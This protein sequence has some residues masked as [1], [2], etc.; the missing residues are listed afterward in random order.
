NV[1]DTYNS[2]TTWT[3]PSDVTSVTVEA[4]GGGGGGGGTSGTS[5]GSGGGGGGY[6]RVNNLTVT[7]G[8][9]Y[10]VTVGTAGAGGAG[11]S[12]NGGNGGDSWFI[13]SAS[14]LAKGGN[15]GAANSGAN[16]TGGSSG[17]G[18]GDAKYSGGNGA[19][20]TGTY[21]GGGGGSGG[22]ANNGNTATTSTGAT[23]VT[24]GGNGGNGATN[25]DGSAP[26]TPPG[27]GGGGGRKNSGGNRD[28]GSGSAGRIVIRYVSSPSNNQCNGRLTE[29]YA[30]TGIFFSTDY[31][32]SQYPPM[33][34]RIL[35]GTN[36]YNVNPTGAGQLNPIIGQLQATTHNLWDA[37]QTNAFGSTAAAVAGLSSPKSGQSSFSSGT[38][39]APYNAGSA[40]AGPQTGYQLDDTAQVGPWQRIYYQGSRMG[41]N[42]TGPAKTA[43]INEPGSSLTSVGGNPTSVGWNLSPGN[44]LPAGTNA[45]RWALG[46]LTVGEIRYV[47]ISLRLTSQVP[48][49][50]IIN[51]SEVF[52]GDA[53]NADDGKDNTWRYHVP[54]VADNNSNLYVLKTVVGYYS[55]STF[56]PN[57]GTYI[58]AG[59]KVRY[60]IVYLNSGNANQTNVILSDTLPCQTNANPVSNITVISG[61][62]SAATSP[63]LTAIPAGNC[64]TTPFTR[65]T[66]SFN[67]GVGV[68]LLPA[69]SGVI[70]FDVQTNSVTGDTVSN[71]AKLA[72]TLI[73]AGVVSNAN[74]F[75]ASSPNLVITKTTSTPTVTAGGTVTYS[76]VIE[77]NGTANA[78]GLTV[79]DM[80]P[81][82]GGADSSLTRFSYAST[83]SIT[84]DPS[85]PPGS[86]IPA[87]TITTAVPPTLLPY[88]TGILASNQQQV[89]WVFSGSTLVPNAKFT[90]TFT[91]TVG[92]NVNASSTPYYNTS[93][94]TYNSTKRTDSASTAGVTV[95]SPLSITKTIESYYDTATS[96]WVPYSNNIPANAKIRYVIDYANIGG[97]AINNVVLT[98]TLPCQTAANSVSNITIVSGPITVPSPNPPVVAAGNCATS[99]RQ[100]FS[101][102]TL[103]SLSAGQT[104]R[105]K[106]DVQTNAAIGSSVINTA[107]LSGTGAPLVS[108]DA[109]TLVTSAPLL[110]ISKTAS[111]SSVSQG[112]SLSYTIT[113]TNTGTANANN[114]VLYDWLPSGGA[115]LNPATRFSYS[116]TTSITGLTSVVPTVVIPP[117]L[118]PFSSDTY[119]ANMQQIAW[120]FTGQTLAP[121]A[122]FTV[123]FQ[124][125]V[126]ASV[127]VAPAYYNNARVYYGTQQ[128]DSGAVGV[129]VGSNLSTSSKTWNDL[130]GGD[131]NPGDIIEYTITLNETANIAANGVSV[132][133]DIPAN[134]N[135][136]TVMSTPPGSTNSSTGAGTGANG[137]GYLN[138][139]GI[140]VAANGTAAIVFRVT[141][142]GGTP[143][144]TQI[145][146]CATVTNPGGVGASPCATTVTVSESTV[147]GY[148]NKPLYFYDA[149]SI[150]AQKLSRTKPGSGA[151]VTI[152]AG[153]FQTWTESPAL[154]SSVTISNVISTTV[155]VQL[156]LSK[157]VA[158]T[159]NVTAGLYCGGTLV[160]SL[161]QSTALTTTPTLYNFNLPLAAPYTCAAGN[162]WAVR[163]TNGGALAI[164]LSPYVSASQISN[165]SLPSQDVITVTSVTPYSTAYPGVTSPASYNAGATVYLRAVVTDPFGSYDITSASITIKDPDNNTIVSSAAMTEVNDSGAAAKTYEYAY[166]IPAGG[167]VGFWTAIVTAK[168]G[169]ENTISDIG[170]GTF[171]VLNSMPDIVVMKTSQTE[172]DP[173][174]GASADAKAIPGA[175]IIYTIQVTNTGAGAVDS[176]TIFITDT[177]PLNTKLYVDAWVPP[178]GAACGPLGFVQ[179]TSTLTCASGNV[180]FADD[181]RPGPYTYDYTPVSAGGYDA[182]VTS[183]QINPQ[184]ILPAAGGGNPY[185]Q[186]KF[187]VRIE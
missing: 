92:A 109:Q 107:S 144:G 161:L 74:S 49:T 117:T 179:G 45:V 145:N 5:G 125:S 30:D 62:I 134:V 140:S 34:T 42:T 165:V 136:F 85:N 53:S 67:G 15:G 186:F 127:P 181:A 174:N 3:A 43:L 180:T 32:T 41:D 77:N 160:T 18:I 83:V 148:G 166:A 123:V 130:N 132:T 27:G 133:D 177:I 152:A 52:G 116:S 122:S 151:G 24:N 93:V 50:G 11:P 29:L 7:P 176:N 143:A 155:P 182:N 58:P 82:M 13:N 139:A 114:I 33:P 185:F 28:G 111:V 105:I 171:W 81:T 65:S 131:A 95:T 55:G 121:G 138:I 38:G 47:K 84:E 20:G 104:G 46:K 25:G 71:T 44:P 154:A 113:V 68:T 36:G 39:A 156:Y 87:P 69:A 169:S 60:R 2:S 98:D 128:A 135:T 162:S 164:T 56:I 101:F 8:N 35:Q 120:T 14:I 1:V 23:A 163:V 22:S 6:S 178:P 183:I 26:T 184:G 172:S 51:S 61:Q 168:E 167:P 158:A 170:N 89:R 76:I 73:P 141:I 94:V 142:A 72:S 37:D 119:A 137:T 54:S 129:S 99:T 108:S 66:F 70:E 96:T 159:Y 124:A 19:T 79:Y 112:G 118:S 97:S 175:D 31:R 115:V 59:A 91:A 80:L 103:A 153:G 10:T 150:P 90:I 86:V 21:G 173:V 157:A 40:V 57:N 64:G 146:N 16:G 48:G 100:T 126:G 63:A 149:S 187:R 9:T 102:P 75:V 88:S 78:T 12:G 106:L 17:S 110:Q 147:P 4:W